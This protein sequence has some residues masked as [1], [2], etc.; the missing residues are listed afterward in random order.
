MPE[1]LRVFLLNALF[2][3]PTVLIA[4]T[5]HEVAHGYISYKMGDPTAR[6]LGRLNLN[7]IKHLDPIGTICMVFF[8]IGWA[9]P[10]PVNARYYKNPKK[11]MALTA[12]AGPIA[13]LILAL[14]GVIVFC[15]IG[16]LAPTAVKEQGLSELILKT[17][18]LHY[19][20]GDGMLA[21][22]I[23]CV[24]LYFFWRFSL[25]NVALAIFNLIPIPP[26]DGSRLALVFL[27]DRIY[28]GIMQY[29]RYI[30]LA[31][32]VILWFFGGFIIY[33]AR[34]LLDGIFWLVKL[35]P[36]F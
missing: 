36:F 21:E 17:G 5:F 7:P 19:F 1:A 15:T 23:C 27:P 16:A 9:K 26:F 4:L 28:F 33:P 13:N 3:L 29:E 10:V 32:L 8:G 14:L 35:I 20:T 6:N 22:N 18:G 2:S 25:L 30:M 24:A 34:A 11:G 31:I 12:A